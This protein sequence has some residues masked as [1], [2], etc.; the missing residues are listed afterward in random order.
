MSLFAPTPEL[1]CLL[2]SS[3]HS[4]EDGLEGPISLAFLNWPRHLR[5]LFCLSSFLAVN[6]RNIFH[7]GVSVEKADLPT[8][9]AQSVSLAAPLDL[10]RQAVA[11]ENG[12]RLHIYCTLECPA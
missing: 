2:D 12:P 11:S 10:P 8:H 3:R 4:V 6:P 7:S 5:L 1:I 9:A